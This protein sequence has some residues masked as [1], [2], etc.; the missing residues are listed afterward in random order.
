MGLETQRRRRGH[1]FFP[2]QSIAK[3][4]PALY[5]TDAQGVD[6][7]V[8]LHYFGGSADWYIT[9]ANFETGLVFGWAELAPGCGE[10]GYSNLPE[11]EAV[12]TGLI[13]IERDLYWEPKPMREVLAERGVRA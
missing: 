8:H 9:E 5:T 3:K 6:A 13:V 11:M 10:W 1:N 2:P 12:N 4:V 7:I